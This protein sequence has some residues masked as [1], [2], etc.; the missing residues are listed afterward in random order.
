MAY[1]GALIAKTLPENLSRLK[2]Q[3]IQKL[4]Y[5]DPVARKWGTVSN[6]TYT[7]GG[8]SGTGTTGSS[9]AGTPA[10]VYSSEGGGE[11]YSPSAYSL[12]QISIKV[13]NLTWSPTNEMLSQYAQS[14]ATRANTV[15][16]PQVSAIAQALARFQTEAQNQ[17]NEINP[18]YTDMSLAL[19]NVIKNQVYQPGVDELIRRN[20]VDSGA[21]RQLQDSSG[22]YEVEQRG[23]VERER[24][25]ILNA[26][27]NQVLGKEQETSDAQTALEKLRGQYTDVYTGEEEDTAYDR[28][29]NEKQSTFQNELSKVSLQNAIAAAAAQAQYNSGLLSSQNARSSWE[30]GQAEKEFALQ[31]ALANYQMRPQAASSPS[32]PTQMVTVPT[33]YGDIPMTVAQ[34]IQAG[35]ISGKKS[36]FD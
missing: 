21:L 36:I 11:S 34:A 1:I 4:S 18:R 27:A 28:F 5:T 15:I 9:P 8:S 22:R 26:L 30:Q 7:S 17:R 33:P 24:N 20:A 31:Q 6:P 13:P 10:Q 35:F 23:N 25:S 29:I 16:D 14:G 32:T 19:A 2:Q 12:P 3:S